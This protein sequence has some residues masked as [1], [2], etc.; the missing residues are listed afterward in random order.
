MEPIACM[1]ILGWCHVGDRSSWGLHE[2]VTIDK[3]FS[4]SGNRG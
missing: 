3:F 1:G 2:E 4:W